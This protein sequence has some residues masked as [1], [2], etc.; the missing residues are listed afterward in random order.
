MALT[1]AQNDTIFL[2]T[3]PFIYFFEE[4]EAWVDKLGELFESA[5]KVNARFITSIITYIELLTLPEKEGDSKLAAKYREFLTNSEQLSI[6]PLNLSVADM[7]VWFR[8]KYGLRTPDSIQLA[9]ARICGA[10]YVV[11]NDKNW[12]KISELN[13][14]LVDEI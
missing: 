14:V 6:Y 2:D 10:D 9:T 5:T 8:A 12:K 11:T 7:T 13:I 4:N 1:I 3:A